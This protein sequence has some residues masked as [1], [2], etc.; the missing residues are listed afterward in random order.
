M[1]SPKPS[2]VFCLLLLLAGCPTAEPPYRLLRRGLRE[3]LFSVAG[4]S[5]SDVWIVGSDA[6]EGPIVLHWDGV[7]WERL[8]TGERG[9]LWWVHPVAGGPVLMGGEDGMVL[10]HDGTRFERM[11]TPARGVIVFGIWAAAP[12]DV[13][14]VGGAGGSNGFVWHHDGRSWTPVTLPEH[15][16]EAVFKVWGTSSSDVWICGFGGL[17]YRFDGARWSRVPSTTSR[18]LLTLHT[19]DGRLAAVGGAGTGVLVERAPDGTFIDATPELAPQLMGVW[20]TPDGG[21]AS[22][23]HGAIFRREAGRWVEEHHELDLLEQLHSVWIDPD[24]GV[25]SVGGHILAE[26]FSGGV[27]VHQGTRDVAPIP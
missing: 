14:A 3:G 18:T 26:P 8:A 15:E 23:I 11:T 22:G 21:R 6:G 10:R 5:A 25:W 2:V 16:G 13:Y 7:Q 9:D 12:D 19:I 24:G 27:V 1:Q 4:R 17:L 20:L